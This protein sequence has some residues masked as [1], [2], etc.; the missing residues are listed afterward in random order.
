M[1][2]RIRGGWTELIRNG[3]LRDA[4][5][6]LTKDYVTAVLANDR[7]LSS[8][9]FEELYKALCESKKILPEKPGINVFK[10][11]E[12]M[13]NMVVEEVFRRGEDVELIIEDFKLNSEFL[14]KKYA[15]KEFRKILKED[16]LRDAFDLDDEKYKEKRE[17]VLRILEDLLEKD[18]CIP[19]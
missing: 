11:L 10:I 12:L 18:Y 6:I 7:Y 5:A 2:W 1:K 14:L 16:L 17:R 4:V 8:I 19:P 13:R 3:Q 15:D 9:I